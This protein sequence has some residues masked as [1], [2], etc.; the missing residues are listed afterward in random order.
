M[1]VTRLFPPVLMLR[2][3]TR[4]SRMHHT[5]STLQVLSRTACGAQLSEV[6]VVFIAYNIMSAI[7]K[8][9]V[10]NTHGNDA[11]QSTGVRAGGNSCV[12]T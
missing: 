12:R 9:S 3:S 8:Y 7:V 4:H 1:G 6:K 10:R 2:F 11:L 5:Q